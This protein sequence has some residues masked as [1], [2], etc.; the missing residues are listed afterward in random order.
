MMRDEG[1]PEACLDDCRPSDDCVDC[2]EDVDWEA[3]EEMEDPC[4]DML[5]E[6]MDEEDLEALKECYMLA[7]PCMDVCWPSDD[8]MMCMMD[9][10]MDGE[11]GEGHGDKGKG[12][13]NFLLMN[14][15]RDLL[16]TREVRIKTCTCKSASSSTL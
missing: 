15:V 7:F 16:M 2:A 8:C 9:A 5:E 11:H 4:E 10:E 6:D 1:M 13:R 12:P 14:S 3:M